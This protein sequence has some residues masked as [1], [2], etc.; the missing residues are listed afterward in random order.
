MRRDAWTKRAKAQP[1][2][3]DIWR[4]LEAGFATGAMRDGEVVTYGRLMQIAETDAHFQVDTVSLLLAEHRS[5][6]RLTKTG[7]N[8]YKVSRRAVIGDR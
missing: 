6:L 4:R 3:R 8:R 2:E 1:A 5:P 7:A